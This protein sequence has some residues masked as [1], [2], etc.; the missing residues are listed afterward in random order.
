[1]A[2]EL[3]SVHPAIASCRAHYVDGHEKDRAGEAKWLIVRSP[4][5]LEDRLAKYSLGTGIEGQDDN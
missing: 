2:Q 1:M 3:D 4:G 5:I